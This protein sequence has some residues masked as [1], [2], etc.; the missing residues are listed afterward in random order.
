MAVLNCE[1][2]RSLLLDAEESIKH[3]LESIDRL[4]LALQKETW[5]E[6]FALEYAVRERSLRREN[7]VTKYESHLH[8]HGS[9]AMTAGG[10]YV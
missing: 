5:S 8:A 10:S 1:I 2:C 9:N 6:L 7:A 4:E 3:H